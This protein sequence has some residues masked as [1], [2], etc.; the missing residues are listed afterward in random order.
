MADSM[1]EARTGAYF[2]EAPIRTDDLI[3]AGGL[4]A[5]DDIGQPLPS[6]MDATDTEEE[7]RALEDP[8]DTEAG[9]TSSPHPGLGSDPSRAP[10]PETDRTDI[11]SDSNSADDIAAVMS[12]D[13]HN[14]FVPGGTESEL[15]APDGGV[16]GSYGVGVGGNKGGGFGVQMGP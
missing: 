2:E 12:Q 8:K 5:R 15:D 9:V 16:T 10:L 1:Q 13:L 14:R 7:L 11:F 4:G 3:R 6:A